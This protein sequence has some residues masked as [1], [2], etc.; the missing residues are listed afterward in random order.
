MKCTD[1]RIGKLIAL[2]EFDQLSDDQKKIFENHIFSCDFC[3]QNLHELSKVTHKMRERPEE[4]LAILKQTKQPSFIQLINKYFN[5]TFRNFKLLL[6]SIPIWGRA[7]F[8]LTVAVAILVIILQPAEKQFSDLAIIEPV[9]YISLETRGDVQV[10]SAA[11]FFE[12][13]MDFYK[14]KDFEPAIEPLSEA[15]NL[16][17]GNAKYYFYLGLTYLLSEQIDA[18]IE[19]FNKAIEY[20]TSTIVEKTHWYLGNIFL[21]KNQPRDA[22]I[23]FQMVIAIE[24]DYEYRARE[25]IEKI[26]ERRNSG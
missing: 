21:I 9:Q 20:G 24:M 15:I 4:Y 6:D 23:E 7:L 22:I 11:Q 1:E 18:G 5:K 19:P 25:M 14:I 3:F 12:R 8:P 26:N 16:E 17:P 13:G 2:Y 10:S